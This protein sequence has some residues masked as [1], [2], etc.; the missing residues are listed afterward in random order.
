MTRRRRFDAGGCVTWRS[1]TRKQLL[2]PNQ[3]TTHT[4]GPESRPVPSNFIF[5][6]LNPQKTKDRFPHPPSAPSGLKV[7]RENQ[8]YRGTRCSLS[9]SSLGTYVRASSAYKLILN[10]VE[11]CAVKKH[12]GPHPEPC[13]T[14]TSEH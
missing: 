8:S 4:P 3:P 2:P 11:A 7:F 13:G 5:F 10:H 6:P 12:R 14:P 9:S 1:L